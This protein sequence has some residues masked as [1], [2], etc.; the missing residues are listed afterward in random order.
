MT[1]GT[2]YSQTSMYVPSYMQ[3]QALTTDSTTN[4]TTNSTAS[5]KKGGIN[6][7]AIAVAGVAVIAGIITYKNGGIKNTLKQIG[8]LFGKNADDA[9]KNLNLLEKAKALFKGTNAKKGTDAIGEALTEAASRTGKKRW[10]SDDIISITKKVDIPD[11][12]TVSQET[13][14]ALQSPTKKET[15]VEGQ[16][17]FDPNNIKPG[18]YVDSNGDKII[19]DKDGTG[20]L[21]RDKNTFQ[22]TTP[23]GQQKFY[24]TADSSAAQ[25]II[26]SPAPQTSKKLSTQNNN[27]IVNYFHDK[28]SDAAFGLDTSAAQAEIKKLE[29]E[30]VPYYQQVKQQNTSTIQ[31]RLEEIA[32][33]EQIDDLIQAGR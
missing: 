14:K 6:I 17:L 24:S 32:Q 4:L 21:V 3:Q 20:I 23:G 30:R 22:I 31:E 25:E 16:Q 15:L 26:A 10:F 33:E 19:V 28:K 12:P 29:A 5:E 2:N 18:Q 13:T 1:I 27:E 8:K 9:A 11:T 7:G